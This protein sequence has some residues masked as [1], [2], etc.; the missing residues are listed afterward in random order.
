[1]LYSLAV[2]LVARAALVI[3]N[4]GGYLVVSA[5]FAPPFLGVPAL[6]LLR[7]ACWVAPGPAAG[8]STGLAL[9]T[10]PAAFGWA[11]FG[12]LNWR[13]YSPQGQIVRESAL[14]GGWR[15]G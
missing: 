13:A 6:A 12:G 4:P 7:A 1:M 8:R 14:P 15:S 2:L 11:W 5:P 3:G 9:A 10:V